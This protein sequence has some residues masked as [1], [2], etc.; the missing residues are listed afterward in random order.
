MHSAQEDRVDW[1]SGRVLITAIVCVV[2]A[3]TAISTLIE[4]SSI[5]HVH[6]SPSTIRLVLMALALLALMGVTVGL[7]HLDC[8]AISRL[9]A[10]LII[11]GGIAN[12]VSAIVFSGCVDCVSSAPFSFLKVYGGPGFFLSPGD[13]LIG[14]GQL[15]FPA[16]LTWELYCIARWYRQ[17]RLDLA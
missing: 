3:L 4:Y 1:W 12:L 9:V 10:V 16:M 5:G 11:S 15:L 14:A 13:L 2:S 7:V 17:A 8:S 6:N